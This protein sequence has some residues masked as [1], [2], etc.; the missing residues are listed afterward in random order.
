MRFGKKTT[1]GRKAKTLKTFEVPPLSPPALS[2]NESTNSVGHRTNIG[3][4]GIDN[5]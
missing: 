3:G 4:S 2:L 5:G 1:C